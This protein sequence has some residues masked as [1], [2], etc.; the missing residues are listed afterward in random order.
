[1]PRTGWAGGPGNREHCVAVR[2]NVSPTLAGHPAPVARGK[3]WLTRPMYTHSR[4]ADFE[5]LP[6]RIRPK[7]GPEAR[8]PAPPKREPKGCLT[9][10]TN[11]LS[12]AP[13]VAPFL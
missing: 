12:P 8:F 1:M 13:P 10:A 6:T 4:K 11:K 2:P 3:V 9:G 7:S 5:F